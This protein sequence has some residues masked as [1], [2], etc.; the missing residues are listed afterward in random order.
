MCELTGRAMEE[1]T[2]PRIDPRD[3]FVQQTCGRI[4]RGEVNQ[5]DVDDLNELVRWLNEEIYYRVNPYIPPA[6]P[7]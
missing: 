5:V 1:A 2:G 3:H 7:F 6:D 4:A